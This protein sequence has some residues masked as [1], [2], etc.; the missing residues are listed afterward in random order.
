VA[1]FYSF[2]DGNKKIDNPIFQ[3]RGQNLTT[4]ATSEKTASLHKIGIEII[5]KQTLKT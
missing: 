2:S 3:N 1:L 4:D 5:E